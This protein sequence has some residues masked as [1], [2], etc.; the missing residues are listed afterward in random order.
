MPSAI[1]ER[2]STE[3]ADHSRIEQRPTQKAVFQI[4][5]ERYAADP[6]PGFVLDGFRPSESAGERTGNIL[7]DDEGMQ[8]SRGEEEEEDEEEETP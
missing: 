3:E 6:A 2:P 7:V 5:E 4:A 8:L 1:I